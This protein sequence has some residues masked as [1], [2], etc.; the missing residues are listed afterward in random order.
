MRYRRNRAEGGAPGA[1]GTGAAMPISAA[2]TGMQSYGASG[3]AGMPAMA[4]GAAGG[5]W[6]VYQQ[7]QQ[8]IST[9]KT[10]SGAPQMTAQQQAML[11]QQQQLAM[12]KVL[13]PINICFFLSF[14]ASRVCRLN[15]VWVR[16][17]WLHPRLQEVGR[18]VL[19]Q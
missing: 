11:Q 15:L 12:R 17:P 13:L 5:N 2:A 4:N 6:A 18:T 1:V 10:G 7:Q 9:L 3:T 16:R 19:L 14:T 8:G